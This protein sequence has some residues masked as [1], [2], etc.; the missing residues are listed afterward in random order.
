MIMVGI[1]L[2][3]TLRDKCRRG[4]RQTGKNSKMGKPME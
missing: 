4:K 1:G 3:T 2:G